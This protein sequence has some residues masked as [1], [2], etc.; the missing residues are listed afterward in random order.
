MKSKGTLKVCFLG[1]VVLE[2]I[3]VLTVIYVLS[4]LSA[5]RMDKPLK[6][7]AGKASMERAANALVNL[8]GETQPEP[9]VL[10]LSYWEQTTNALSNLA[11]LQCWAKTVNI[12]KVVEP[13]ITPETPDKSS[14]HFT[15]SDENFR[16][17]DLYNISHWNER[18]TVKRNFS[19]LVST[20]HFFKHA[21]K[22]LVYVWIRYAQRPIHCKFNKIVFGREWYRSLLKKGFELVKTVCIDL[23][24][25]PSHVMSDKQ[26]RDEIFDG[27][28]RNVTV[29]FDIWRGIRSSIRLAL[30]GTRCSHNSLGISLKF[31]GTP[32]PVIQYGQPRARPPLV[33]SLRVQRFVDEF[34]SEHLLGSKYI[35]VMVRTEKLKKLIDSLPLGN[36]FCAGAIVSDWRKMADERNITKTLFFSDIGKHGSMKWNNTLALDF[37]RYIHNNIRLTLSLDRVNTL[38]EGLTGS[39]DSIQI[40]FLHQQL[41]ARATC[42]VIVGGGGFQSHALNAYLHLHQ[43]QECYSYRGHTC[44]SSYIELVNG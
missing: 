11:D 20:G 39:N 35:A 7:W 5:W 15:Q 1:L 33:P 21:T 27:V 13:S 17:S 26:F 36:N 19:R 40:A 44:T 42:V 8:A 31:T 2:A 22:R 23:K 14:L 18:T 37:S 24:K 10:S 38:L 32:V 16:L 3:G 6:S 30:N 29:V 9:M 12:G 41:V 43:G 34:L 25:E 4:P 28:G